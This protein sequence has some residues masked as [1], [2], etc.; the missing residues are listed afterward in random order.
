M[1]K[2]DLLTKYIAEGEHDT[3]DFKETIS[4]AR[5]IAKTLVS[6]ANTRGGRI[7]VGVRDNTTLRSIDPI[8]EQH[9]L[10]TAASTYC[11]P[12]LDLHF[13]VLRKGPNRILV[14]TVD[15]ST[16]KPHFALGDDGEWWCYIRV[17]DKSLLASKTV[18]DVLR[19]S[20]SGENT[21][22]EFGSKEQALMDYLAKNDR[23]TLKEYSKLINIG[24]RRARRILV[25]L[26]SAGVIRI[27]TT[28]KEEFYTTA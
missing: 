18:L 27:H 16:E 26:V 21:L 9:I 5:K 24:L 20:S 1:E 17:K 7:L 4:D 15:E 12:P 2:I 13:H 25:D 14:A 11:D 19:K 6:F 3:Q 8:G 22:I 10:E 28:E 23:I